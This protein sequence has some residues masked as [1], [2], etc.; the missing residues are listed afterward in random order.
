MDSGLRAFI[1]RPA[2][3]V[4]ATAD[5]AGRPALCRVMG[6][7]PA[8]ADG[9]LDLFISA[10]QWPRVLEVLGAGGRLALTVCRPETYETYQ[11]KGQVEE[12]AAP[13]AADQIFADGYVERMSAH[14]GGLGVEPAQMAP[15][16]NASGLVRVRMRPQRTFSQTPGPDAG[17]PLPDGD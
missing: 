4:A 5:A 16:L 7:R 8:E 14:L 1:E 12:L 11:V 13:E 15:W 3:M 17:A 10:R 6:A 2:M 9:A